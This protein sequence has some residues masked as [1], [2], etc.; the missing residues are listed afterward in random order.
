MPNQ[1]K[2]ALRD[3]ARFRIT[4]GQYFLAF[5]SLVSLLGLGI[6]FVTYSASAVKQAR[7]LSDVETPA[8]SIIFTQRETLVYATRLAQW[9]NG[10]ITRREVQIARNLLAQRLA[11]VD[12]SGKSM[13]ERAA[14]S[15]WNALLKSDALVATTQ[16]GILPES[17]HA[18]MT[19]ELNPVIDAI[20]GEGRK[21]VVSY[22]RV[23]DAR[24]TENAKMQAEKIQVMLYFF[25][26]F[27]FFTTLF[28]ITNVRTNFKN[29]RLAREGITRESERLNATIEELKKTQSTVTV[30]QDLNAQKNDF[31]STI[32]HELRTPLTSIIGYIDVIREMKNKD[33][34]IDAYLD[35]LDRNADILLNLVE[36]V[37]SLSK[38]DSASGVLPSTKVSLIRVL[39]DAIFVMKPASES[40]G[41]VI[42]TDFDPGLEWDVRGDAGQLKQVFINL[43]GNAIKFSPR[44][45]T[46]EVSFEQVIRGENIKFIRIKVVDHGIGIPKEDLQNLFTRFFRAKNAVSNQYPGT[47]LGLSI[48]EQSI[49][50]HGGVVSVESE[51]G[52]G[53]TFIIDL[54]AFQNPEDELIAARR[55]LVVSRALTALREASRETLKAVTHSI[56]GAL[57][58]YGFEIEGAEI[59]EFSRDLSEPITM[60]D[61][62]IF[63]RQEELISLLE[64]VLKELNQESNQK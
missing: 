45:S 57:G 62:E 59:L 63:V 35:V 4:R 22:Q 24:I 20:L 43:L 52:K 28:L 26:I 49:Q 12:S 31:I 15:Y 39:D 51:E 17:L 48:V 18:E 58:F 1:A 32:N 10:G 54:P 19:Q 25:Y 5:A 60:S 37:L 36:S 3:V 30:L 44:E 61:D 14:P 21:L 6:S 29:Y 38:I 55:G 53:T 42:S 34:E 40:S 46:I 2:N 11:V 27:I 56:G 33:P 8:A 7:V 23:V 47:G 64:N 9:S 13:G 50:H 16:P 41:I